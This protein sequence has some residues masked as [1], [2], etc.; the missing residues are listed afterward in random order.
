MVG[1]TKRNQE[2]C[3]ETADECAAIQTDTVV[4]C[5]V[6]VCVDH[7]C[8]DRGVCDG[9]EDCELPETCVAGLCSPP[10]TPPD[11]PLKPAFDIVYPN[12]WRFSVTGQPFPMDLVVVN[13]DVSPL[14]M[15]TLQVK[16]VSDDHPTAF[17]RFVAAPSS[18]A[19][20]PGEAGGAISPNASPIL[21]PLIPE[22]RVDTQADYIQFEIVDAPD[23][24]YDIAADA[25]LALDG[26]DFSV[27]LTIHMQDT[28]TVFADPEEATRVSIQK[29]P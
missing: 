17:V 19:I 29:A 24:T 8:V 20:A 28:Q 26:V 1:C 7:E 4:S 2:V 25:E 10:T 5:T 11:A 18:A 12:V 14:S 22:P 16:S 9:N 27:H 13:A 3:C 23:G 15:T 21:S 6:G